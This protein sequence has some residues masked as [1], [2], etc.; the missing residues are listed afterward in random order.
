MEALFEG[1]RTLKTSPVN[2]EI[3]CSNLLHRL[4]HSVAGGR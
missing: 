4:A 2:A 1:E 3:F